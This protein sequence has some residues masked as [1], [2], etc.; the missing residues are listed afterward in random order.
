MTQFHETQIH[1]LKKF[2]DAYNQYEKYYLDDNYTDLVNEQLDI[3]NTC[4]NNLELISMGLGYRDLLT[5][6]ESDII[7]PPSIIY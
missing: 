5:K 3:M 4:K 1:L 2:V 7:T 6:L